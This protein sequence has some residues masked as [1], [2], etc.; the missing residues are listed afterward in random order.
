M[1]IYLQYE[2]NTFSIS[3]R[4]K[5]PYE[6]Q[7]IPAAQYN[8]GVCLRL[9]LGVM[10][11]DAEAERLYSA[12]A[13]QGHSSAQ[14]ALGSLQAQAATTDAEWIQVAGWYRLASE[15]GHPTAMISLAQLHESGRGVPADLGAALKLY[16]RALAAGLADAAAEVQR[17]EA[18]LEQSGACV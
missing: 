12:A 10:P 1:S 6:A 9:G 5:R 17:V 13:K 15:A 4:S 18:A 11:D 2:R 14:L 16:Q 3:A 7:A 8:L